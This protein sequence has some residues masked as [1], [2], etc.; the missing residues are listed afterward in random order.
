M[1]PIRITKVN[2]AL[3]CELCGVVIEEGSNVCARCFEEARNPPG[4]LP[5]PEDPV[6]SVGDD[7]DIP[8]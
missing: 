3:V 6:L 7:L 5:C 4:A 1:I 8:F 2:M